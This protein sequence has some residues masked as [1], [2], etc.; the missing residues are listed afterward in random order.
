M[1]SDEVGSG[2][3][4]VKSQAEYVERV[5]QHVYMCPESLVS[6]WKQRLTM[7]KSHW[8]CTQSRP[9]VTKEMKSLFDLYCK[10]R[11]GTRVCTTGAWGDITSTY[12]SVPYGQKTTRIGAHVQTEEPYLFAHRFLI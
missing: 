12:P 1:K 2:N 4:Q 11:D 7:V 9:L 5:L 3:S 6:F 10:Y 8:R